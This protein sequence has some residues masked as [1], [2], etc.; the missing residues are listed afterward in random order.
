MG[1]AIA[2]SS[3]PFSAQ[4]PTH[5]A[6]AVAAIGAEMTACFT[7]LQGL[8]LQHEES[9]I[10]SA[11]SSTIELVLAVL[12]ASFWDLD[13]SEP[14]ALSHAI[15]FLI[16]TTMASP[17]ARKDFEALNGE[18]C[19]RSLMEKSIGARPSPSSSSE[20]SAAA[21]A[22]S[23]HKAITLDA[24]RNS[25]NA[26]KCVE[27]L[28]LLTS[29]RNEE[30]FDKT[31]E[32]IKEH[33]VRRPR[34]THRAPSVAVPEKDGRVSSASYDTELQR[35]LRNRTEPV[36]RRTRSSSP[37]KMSDQHDREAS[38]NGRYDKSAPPSRAAEPLSG[39]ERA[40]EARRR[41]SQS[42]VKSYPPNRLSSPRKRDAGTTTT[43]FGRSARAVSAQQSV[44]QHSAP[45]IPATESHTP[46]GRS[47]ERTPLSG[48]MVNGDERRTQGEHRINEKRSERLASTAV[49][50]SPEGSGKR[51]QNS[52]TERKSGAGGLP[53]ASH[54]D[55]GTR[56]ALSSPLKTM[57]GPSPAV[58]R[59]QAR[60]VSPDKRRLPF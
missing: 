40:R 51:S 53:L 37:V 15:D 10:I 5:P 11:R 52:A 20:A 46:R 42:P 2:S 9:K 14:V 30:A 19:V 1:T 35:R 26:M 13:R 6:D 29:E 34:Q 31:F 28:L 24:V 41:A 12:A 54:L 43:L 3:S 4:L 17:Q 60:S 32:F 50:R 55:D 58:R 56:S 38:A 39:L 59:A 27:L 8:C 18:Q 25:S 57:M 48:V 21:V 22:T 33:Q 7:I 45:V 44:E 47:Q 36:L 49:G 16:C 23:P